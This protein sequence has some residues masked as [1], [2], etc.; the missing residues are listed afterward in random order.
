MRPCPRCAGLLVVDEW[1][2]QVEALNCVAFRC[3]NC[4]HW[5]D[6]GAGRNRVAP[7]VPADGRTLP[8][9]VGASAYRVPAAAG[10]SFTGEPGGRP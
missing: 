1:W 6:G 10:A 9:M 3:L 7:P 2:D 5:D 8:R 4:G